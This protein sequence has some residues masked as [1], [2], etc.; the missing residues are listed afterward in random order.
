MKA[1]CKDDWW[2][3][4][5][6]KQRVGISNIMDEIKYGRLKIFI[7]SPGDY[8][9]FLPCASTAKMYHVVQDHKCPF[10]PQPVSLFKI[11]DLHINLKNQTMKFHK[12]SR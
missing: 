10:I 11:R 2:V 8:N 3:V 12:A 7:Y 4:E 9:E 1:V 6:G 5:E